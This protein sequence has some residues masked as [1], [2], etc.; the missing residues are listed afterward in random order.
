M[1]SAP[2]F[3]PLPRKR[4]LAK[5]LFDLNRHFIS[6]SEAR[7]SKLQII[8]N[9]Q[10][11]AHSC[12]SG[13][14]SFPTARFLPANGSCRWVL[15]AAP[16]ACLHI[17]SCKQVLLPACRRGPVGSSCCLP[18]GNSLVFF[19]FFNLPGKSLLLLCLYPDLDQLGLSFKPFKNTTIKLK[20][21]QA[22]LS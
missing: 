8:A 19:F 21:K 12:Y 11:V 14:W 5:C 15:W 10:K 22:K 7:D 6:G 1:T 20:P 4:Q 3:S 2:N 17:G 13:F 18:V 16:S 9:E